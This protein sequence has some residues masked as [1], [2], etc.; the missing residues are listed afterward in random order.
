MT[1]P[2]YTGRTGYQPT[3]NLETLLTYQALGVLDHTQIIELMDP[4]LAAA[5]AEIE[6]E[7]PDPFRTQ[8]P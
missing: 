1:H 2:N 4:Y 3:P 7:I 8:P 5:R 6:Q